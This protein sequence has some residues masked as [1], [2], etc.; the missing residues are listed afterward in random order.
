M[1]Y[2]GASALERTRQWFK[3]VVCRCE[4]T[5][6]SFLPRVLATGLWPSGHRLFRADDEYARPVAR[7]AGPERSKA[8][9]RNLPHRLLSSVPDPPVLL[10]R[11]RTTT[12][13]VHRHSSP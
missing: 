7:F 3:F 9:V 1:D 12:A 6:Y 10:S 2:P 8:V 13:D 11:Q 5:Q 4:T